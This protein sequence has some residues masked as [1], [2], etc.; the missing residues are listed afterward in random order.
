MTRSPLKPVMNYFLGGELTM[1]RQQFSRGKWRTFGRYL[2]KARKMPLFFPR[3]GDIAA[4][5]RLQ[6]GD[7][8][9]LGRRQADSRGGIRIGLVERLVFEERLRE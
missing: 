6:R 4:A 5:L 9:L 2:V 3:K 8:H 7:R 1:V